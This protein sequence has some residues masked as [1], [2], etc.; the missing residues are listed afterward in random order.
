MNKPAIVFSSALWLIIELRDRI[1]A[2]GEAVILAALLL[3]VAILPGKSFCAHSPAQTPTFAPEAVPGIDQVRTSRSSERHVPAA[4]PAETAPI[5]P[6]EIFRQYLSNP[7]WIRHVS[8][9]RSRNY[10]IDTITDPQNP[11][12]YSGFATFHGALQPGG[13]Y[14]NYQT[15]AFFYD[16]IGHPRVGEEMI[17]GASDRFWWQLS[18]GHDVLS[19]APRHPEDGQSSRHGR[20]RLALYSLAI[21]KK[22][23]LFGMKHLVDAKIE[24]LDADCF[25][26]HSEEHGLVSGRI[27]AYSN[28]LPAR[29]EYSVPSDAPEKHTVLLSYRDSQDKRWYP[30]FQSVSYSELDPARRYTN[31]ILSI[32]TGLEEGRQHGYRPSEFRIKEQPLASLLISSNRATYTVL[33]SGAWVPVQDTPPDFAALAERKSPAAISSSFILAGS[34][35]GLLL[36]GHAV[37]RSR[38]SG[39]HEGVLVPKQSGNA[40]WP[41]ATR[42]EGMRKRIIR[43]MGW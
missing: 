31:I 38:P 4:S 2:R 33:E 7:P 32:D 20:E 8:F 25:Q 42:I 40:V 43:I 30:P 6:A 27:A 3:T 16:L 22:V 41:R 23:R 36:L 26:A 13:F 14:L 39:T 15:N 12:P 35:V 28:A 19:L 17:F 34:L 21:L 18:S 11:K 24:W 9:F 29:I 37:R 5:D 1:P 10:E